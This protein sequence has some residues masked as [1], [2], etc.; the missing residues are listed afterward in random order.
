M[1]QSSSETTTSS[2]QSSCCG[3]GA[4]GHTPWYADRR[5]VIPAAI[6]LG[7]AGLWFG[8]P[9]L[10]VAGLA[11]FIVALLPCLIMC[12]A[13]CALKLCSK[14]KQAEP[15]A[16]ATPNPVITGLTPPA[17]A[18]AVL[19]QAMLDR[20]GAEGTDASAKAPVT[21]LEAAATDHS[22]FSQPTLQQESAAETR[23]PASGVAEIPT[24]A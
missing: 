10:V 9:W 12:G 18:A 20:Q 23:A 15:A 16:G 21:A 11:P 7:G 4:A 17:A 6:A 14:P 5:L 1:T 22:Q 24:R 2:P 13:M 19:S 8:W 3:T